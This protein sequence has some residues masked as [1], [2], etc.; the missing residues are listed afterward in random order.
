MLQDMQQTVKKLLTINQ[1]AE[2][3][4]YSVG[5]LY[6]LVNRGE[7]PCVKLSRKALRFDPDEIDRW[8]AEQDEK[9]RQEEQ[10]AKTA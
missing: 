3:L 6:N 2:K 4:S 5:H 10:T 7:I 1:L 9:T 8:I